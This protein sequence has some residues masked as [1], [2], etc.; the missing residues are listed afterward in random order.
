MDGAIGSAIQEAIKF[1]ILKRRRFTSKG[2]NSTDKAVVIDYRHDL[3]R[4][5]KVCGGGFTKLRSFAQ[6]MDMM[7]C[8][9]RYGYEVVKDWLR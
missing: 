8:G 7:K 9:E 5:K 1:P 3:E 2:A 4:L 6:V